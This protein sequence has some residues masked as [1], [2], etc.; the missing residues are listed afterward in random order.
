M[1]RSAERPGLFHCSLQSR[2]GRVCAGWRVVH[3]PREPVLVAGQGSAGALIPRALLS[4]SSRDAVLGSGSE[5]GLVA[6]P[7]AEEHLAENSSRAGDPLQSGN[8]LGL[9]SL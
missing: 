8:V 7:R 2:E 9:S 3:A 6:H 1:F 4:F 5:R